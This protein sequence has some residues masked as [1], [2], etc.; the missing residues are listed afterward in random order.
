M[1][2]N[3]I[4]HEIC[5]CHIQDSNFFTFKFLLVFGWAANPILDRIHVTWPPRN[6][7]PAEEMTTCLFD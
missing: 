7:L 2:F 6:P 1:N 3:I 4:Q 5:W